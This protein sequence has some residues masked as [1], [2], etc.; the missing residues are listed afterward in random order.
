MNNIILK[1]YT[2]VS[3][4]TSDLESE[5]NIPVQ[6]VEEERLWVLLKRNK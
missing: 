5:D 3:D 6:L 1:D 2:K 4:I